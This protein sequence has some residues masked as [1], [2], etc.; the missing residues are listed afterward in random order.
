MAD[1]ADVSLL[2]VVLKDTISGCTGVCTTETE[3]LNGCIRC[4]LEPGR[5]G[6]G[7]LVKGVSFDIQ[8]LESI[9]SNTIFKGKILRPK[10]PLGVLARDTVTS[11]EGVIVA[12]SSNLTGEPDYAIQPKELKKDGTP[13]EA[14]WFDEGRIVVVKEN[15]TA[16]EKPAK[17]TGGPQ[18][19]CPPSSDGRDR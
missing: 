1:N 15:A 3:Y 17:K 5:N 2:G 8:Q 14:H 11:F 19:T 18:S 12:R 4:I 6:D 7:E 13:K 9:P 10:I 16:A